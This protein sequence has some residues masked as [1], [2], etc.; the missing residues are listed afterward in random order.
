MTKA[1]RPGLYGP[2]KNPRKPKPIADRFWPKVDKRG[3]N[4]CW[5]WTGAARRKDEG[6]GAFWRDGRHQPA[7]RIAYEITNGPIEPHLVICHRCDNPPCCNPAH[8]FVGE[9]PDND[10]DRVAKGRQC[11]GES[12]GTA[13]LTAEQVRVIRA[14]RGVKTRKAI[15]PMFGITTAYVGELWRRESWKH[16]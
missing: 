10:A 5:P 14:L 6:Y 4:E 15:A 12:V 8:L 11:K 7:S 13:K 9:R 2:H 16:L 3:P 1:M